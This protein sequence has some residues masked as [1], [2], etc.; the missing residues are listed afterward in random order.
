MI[1]ILTIFRGFCK[2]E[3]VEDIEGDLLER[4]EKLKT[5]KGHRF[6]DW[7]LIA[8]VLLLLRPGIIRTNFLNQKLSNMGLIQHNLTL[9][10]RNF[11]RHKTSFLINLLGLTTGL[12]IVLLI[13]LWVS[14]ELNMDKFHE[15]QENLYSIM[16][17]HSDASGI[18]TWRGVPGL[19]L[20]EIQEK[21]PEVDYAVAETDSHEVTFSKDNKFLKAY[22]RF[23]SNDFFQTYTYQIL[24]GSTQNVL[25][26]HSSAIITRSFAQNLFKSEEVIGETFTWNFEGKEISFVVRAVIEDAPKNSSVKFDVLLPWD[27]YHDELTNFKIWTNYYARIS[28]VLN[29]SANVKET[30]RKIDQIL[31]SHH[32]EDR[33]SLILVKYADKYLFD[34]YVNGQQAGG[35]IEYVRLFSVVA[36]FILIIACINFMNLSTARASRRSKEVGIKKAIGANRSSLIGQFMTESILITVIS[37]ALAIFLAFA[38]L[39][40]F[41]FLTQKDLTLN[42]SGEFILVI[43][44]VALLT[45]LLAGSYPSLYLSRFRT[46]EVIKG[47]IPSSFAEFWL[48]RGLVVFQFSLSVFF[49]VS[50][51]FIQRQI[52]FVLEKN[53]GYDRENIIYFEKEGKLEHSADAFLSELRSLPEVK[54]AASSGFVLGGINST[55][56][57]NWEGKTPEDQIQFWEIRSDYRTVEI[58][59]IELVAGR[60]FLPDF[61]DTSSVIFNEAAIRTMGMENPIGKTIRHY[62]GDRRIVGIVKDFHVS[63]L[64]KKVEPALFLFNPDRTSQ[65]MIKIGSQN[66]RDAIEKIGAVYEKFNPGY[67]FKFRFL[68]RDYEELYNSEIRSASLSGYF[69]AFA[70]LISCLGL[71]GLAAFTTEK[72]IKEIGIRKILG[73]G[74]WRIILLLS[75]DFTKMVFIA[76]LIA[77]PLSFFLIKEWLQDFSYHISLD[78]WV[79]ALAGGISLLVSWLTI[80][81]QTYKA[82][83]FNPAECLRDE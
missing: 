25:T 18:W 42:F 40:Q 69:A 34:N 29:P 68:D 22:L 37:M 9:T 51:I 49:I 2:P 76:V 83:T 77:M 82:A 41:N 8:E 39:P 61:T 10:L 38:F 79:F 15:N 45:G 72:K 11:A 57:V 59:D 46:I 12:T 65:V 16:S 60:Y 74:T 26:D 27:Y 20:D 23:G 58:L 17:N 48:R 33:V 52:D 80:S 43:L 53:L 28:L 1:W 62:E 75:G 3:F 7:K 19:L 50:V 14:D 4:Y 70:I 31:K 64:H 66:T 30:E 71:F 63:S 73:A 5:T 24:S 6:A 78:W 32:E 36:I 56:G 67:P 54:E 35:R 13:Y 21:V 81:V 55:G 44:T 47:R